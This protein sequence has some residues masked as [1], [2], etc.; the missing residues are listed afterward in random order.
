MLVT[1]RQ[2]LQGFLAAL[3]A[4]AVVPWRL[5]AQIAL[6]TERP[7]AIYPPQG[8]TLDLNQLRGEI[9]G[10]DLVESDKLMVW[11][12]K[13]AEEK[14]PGAKKLDLIAGAWQQTE[15][16]KL[17]WAGGPVGDIGNL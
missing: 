15:S 16:N 8:P 1:R 2:V 3:F 9:F 11:L 13:V 14:L 4:N 5:E 12:R 17:Y 10:N 6:N 7:P